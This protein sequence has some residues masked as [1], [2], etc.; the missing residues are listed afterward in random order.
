MK[1]VESNQKYVIESVTQFLEKGR[2]GF[3]GSFNIKCESGK[4]T[5]DLSLSFVLGCQ[6]QRNEDSD[7][8]SYHQTITS[9]RSKKSPSRL[10]RN[11]LRAEK[12]RAKKSVTSS[13]EEVL[14]T[15]DFPVVNNGETDEDTE[16]LSKVNF[17]DIIED[18]GSI[19]D[20]DEDDSS[21]K[22][23][24]AEDDTS[25]Y[26]PFIVFCETYVNELRTGHIGL[27]IHGYKKQDSASDIPKDR[28]WRRREDV[29]VAPVGNAK[30]FFAMHS[31]DRVFKVYY[32]FDFQEPGGYDVFYIRLKD[33]DDLYLYSKV[34]HN[35]VNYDLMCGDWIAIVEI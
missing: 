35:Q 28:K 16:D 7:L 20:E 24:I 15:E 8:S 23:A 4:V 14:V 19:F 26:L 12:Y 10:R 9:K 30:N 6:E 13:T 2:N 11:W 29:V 3:D 27:G 5:M 17:M 22:D 21:C 32:G 1:M 31:K 18:F 33:Y 25:E 34:V